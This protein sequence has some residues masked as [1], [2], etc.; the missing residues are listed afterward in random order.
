MIVHWTSLDLKQ[1]QVWAMTSFDLVPHPASV[2]QSSRTAA[3]ARDK[4]EH[5]QYFHVNVNSRLSVPGWGYSFY[6]TPLPPFSYYQ[7]KEHGY[8]IFYGRPLYWTYLHSALNLG[9]SVCK[10]GRIFE[11]LFFFIFFVGVLFQLTLI[12]HLGVMTRKCV[13][14]VSK[15]TNWTDWFLPKFQQRTL[16]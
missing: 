11:H 6:D 8:L 15:V 1:V 16:L 12:T 3:L 4:R 10:L 7:F 14:N 5:N 9:W 2:S 13:I